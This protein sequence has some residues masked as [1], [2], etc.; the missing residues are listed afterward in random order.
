MS[1]RQL[2]AADGGSPRNGA[3]SSVIG[4]GGHPDLVALYVLFRHQALCWAGFST[5]IDEIAVWTDGVGRTSDRVGSA[6]M[7]EFGP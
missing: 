7:T 2:L 5:I 1:G 6:P 4:G 3:E